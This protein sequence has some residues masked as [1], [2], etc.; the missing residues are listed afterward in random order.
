MPTPSLRIVIDDQPCEIA[1]GAY[2]QAVNAAAAVVQE[3]GR[4]IIEVAIDGETVELCE[5]EKLDTNC[6]STTTSEIQI[7]TAE[8]VELVGQVLKD[9]AAALEEADSLQQSA[10]ES[11][12]AGKLPQAM[13][14]LSIALG[15][16]SS[17]QQALAVGAQVPGLDLV[18]ELAS[19]HHQQAVER[20]N[21]HLRAIRAAL[22]SRDPVGLSDTLLYDLPDVVV[23]WRSLLHE[24][25]QRLTINV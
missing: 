18:V 20:L 14:S 21:T 15:I 1:A 17:V 25:R 3:R 11:I 5:L 10:A 9:A 23:Q 19:D 16:W 7:T 8:P 4:M 24:L 12:Q 22:E 2:M 6:Q 13:Q